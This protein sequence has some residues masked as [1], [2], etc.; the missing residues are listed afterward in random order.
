MYYF[1]CTFWSLLVKA[2]VYC[3]MLKVLF[4]HFSILQMFSWSILLHKI[5][6]RCVKLLLSLADNF[7]NDYLSHGLVGN[8]S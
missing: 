4:T 6:K 7:K 1:Y 5:C 3:L 2:S 8:Y